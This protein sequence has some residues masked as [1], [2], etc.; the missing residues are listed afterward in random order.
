M[1]N[2]KQHVVATTNEILDTKSGKTLDRIVNKG[3]GEDDKQK[4]VIVEINY[5][6]MF[7]SGSTKP[8][9]QFKSCNYSYNDLKT[10]IN[11]KVNREKIDYWI[12]IIGMDD[13]ATNWDEFTFIGGCVTK[14]PI[15][16]IAVDYERITV[17]YMGY[18]AEFTNNKFHTITKFF[19]AYIPSDY[20]PQN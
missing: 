14:V 10:L 18:F 2:N 17:S 9:L 13:T 7:E 12:R 3:G 4:D 15:I 1:A 16:G 8:S 11:N 19:N 6:I 20:Q 5:K